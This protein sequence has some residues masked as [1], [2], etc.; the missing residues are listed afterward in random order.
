MNNLENILNTKTFLEAIV[1]G[2][3]TFMI[4]KIAFNITINKNNIK[5]DEDKSVLY[6]IDLT[7]FVTGFLLHF[8]IE[9]IG[10]NKWYCDK[11]CIA[12]VSNLA[13]I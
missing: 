4:G 7:F 1:I 6:G 2:L 9:I 10:L 11:Q 8:F 3:I 13:K 5:D 12:G